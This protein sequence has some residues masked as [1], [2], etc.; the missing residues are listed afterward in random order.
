VP[1]FVIIGQTIFEISRFSD[2]DFRNSQ[3]LLAEGIRR[4]EMNIGKVLGKKMGVSRALCALAPSCLKT[5][6]NSSDIFSTAAVVGLIF[7]LG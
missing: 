1:N 2:L 7:D 6:T 4:A 5:N 3:I